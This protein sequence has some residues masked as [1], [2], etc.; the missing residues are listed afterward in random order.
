MTRTKRTTRT[1]A[2]RVVR[3]PAARTPR[4]ALQAVR[5]D[6]KAAVDMLISRAPALLEKGRRFAV[7]RTQE[8][9]DA[10]LAR[11]GEA[12]S[13]TVDAVSQLEK[14]FENRVSLAISRLGVPTAR[15]VRALSRQVAQLQASVEQLARKRTRA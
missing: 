2:A 15:D 5:R 13:R 3:R 6:A 9:R 12:R 14:V 4:Q 10:V 1:R 8:A 11:A 7:S